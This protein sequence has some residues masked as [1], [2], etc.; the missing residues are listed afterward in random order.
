MKMCSSRAGRFKIFA[1]LKDLF[2]ARLPLSLSLP[3]SLPLSLL[4]SLPLSLSLSLSL[5]C[6]QSCRCHCLCV[7]LYRAFAFAVALVVAFALLLQESPRE[8]VMKDCLK[9]QNEDLASL[10]TYRLV[11]ATHTHV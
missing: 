1:N 11:A 2:A 8:L 6:R 9:P 10:C 5:P 7:Y 3:L 4:L